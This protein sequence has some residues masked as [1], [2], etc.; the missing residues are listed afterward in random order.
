ME[1][2]IKWSDLSE[3]HLKG[4]FDFYSFEASPEIAKKII[5]GI[6]KRV[7]ILETNPLAGQRE[8]LLS[9]YP[10]DFRYLVEGNYKIIYWEKEKIITIASVFDS[11]QNPGKIKII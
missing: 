4:I 1:I 10:E 3:R 9:D 5:N 6:I 8:E 7:S 2:R 11:R